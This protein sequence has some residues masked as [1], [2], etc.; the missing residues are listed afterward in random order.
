M[1]YWDSKI[2]FS[3]LFEL[4]NSQ[5]MYDKLWLCILQSC[6]RKVDNFWGFLP[7]QSTKKVDT[8]CFANVFVY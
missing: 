8:A 1:E 6:A 2:P 5:W 7:C 4:R 3:N